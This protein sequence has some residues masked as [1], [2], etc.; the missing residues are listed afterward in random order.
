MAQFDYK[1]FLKE[2]GIE[3][4]LME[5]NFGNDIED[6]YEYIRPL[7]SR[8][9]DSARTEALI[10]GME[11]GLRE[12]DKSLFDYYFVEA[13]KMLGLEDELMEPDDMMSEPDYEDYAPDSALGPNPSF[14][15]EVASEEFEDLD[16]LGLLDEELAGIFAKKAMKQAGEKT[17]YMKLRRSF[18]DYINP[19]AEEIDDEDLEAAV[20]YFDD[21]AEND[22]VLDE[23][24]DEGMSDEEYA[25]AQEKERLEKHPERDKI[26]AIQNLVKKEKDL[27]EGTWS[28][29]GPKDIDSIISGLQGLIKMADD[30]QNKKNAAGRG[31]VNALQNQ[32]KS[33]GWTSRLYKTVGDDTF[34]DHYDAANSAAAVRDFDKVK[35]HLGDAIARAEELKATIM[36]NSGIG[37]GKEIKEGKFKAGDMVRL[38]NDGGVGPEF[39][40]ISTRRMFG[41]NL[42]AVRVTDEKGRTTEYDETQLDLSWSPEQKANVFVR[43]MEGEVQTES[44]EKVLKA[45]NDLEDALNNAVDELT[46]DQIDTITNMILDLRD[47]V[48]VEL[49]ARKK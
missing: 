15:E 25:D 23:I 28:L 2:G 32:L 17:D 6:R 49:K 3:K 1:K 19:E 41:K 39:V 27:K 18:N 34:F 40:V 12:D 7:M 46:D 36:K 35:N 24:I 47:K 38:K 44:I 29:G 31:F 45:S 16:D 4:Y 33:E 43:E 11:D 21:L 5:A 8:L 26:R 22:T 14:V 42:E 37:E 13:M 10:D 48:K 30:A 9:P 20:D